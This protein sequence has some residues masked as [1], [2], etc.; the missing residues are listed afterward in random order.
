MSKAYDGNNVHK[1]ALQEWKASCTLLK[2]E[3]P[4]ARMNGCVTENQQCMAMCDSC[5]MVGKQIEGS[6]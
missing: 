4:G 1:S 5:N 3:A 2:L 6:F